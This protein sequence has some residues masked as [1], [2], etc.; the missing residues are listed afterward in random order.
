MPG[1]FHLNATELLQEALEEEDSELV[2][3]AIRRGADVNAMWRDQT[4]LSAAVQIGD[5]ELIKL[6]LSAGADPNRKNDDGN[7]A[8]TWCV[9]TEMTALLLDAGASVRAELGKEEMVDYSSVH[10]AADNGDAARLQ[11]LLERGDAKCMLDVFTDLGWAPL[12]HAA[13]EGHCEAAQLL[14]DAGAD[15]NLVYEDRIGDTAIYLAARGG[16]V[17]MVK[18]L[19]ASGADPALQIGL[20][21]SA[22]DVARQSTNNP[23]LLAS[24]EEALRRR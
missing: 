3:E 13:N 4:M 12:H 9:T 7:T 19:L 5:I 2:A 23:E 16:H 17:E 21:S 18:L 15:P 1:R 8:L 24:I 14:I 11:V 6:L 10:H 22:L 20:N